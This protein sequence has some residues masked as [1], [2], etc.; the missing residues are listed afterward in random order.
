[1]GMVRMVVV[2]VVVRRGMTF[3]SRRMGFRWVIGIVR[4]ERVGEVDH[5]G[6]ESLCTLL[7]HEIVINLYVAANSH[8]VLYFVGG[9][10]VSSPRLSTSA[11]GN[12]SQY[13]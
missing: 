11:G 2:V 5:D 7:Y 3:V 8:Y 12:I 4:L 6:L 13:R 1:M 9:L 10:F